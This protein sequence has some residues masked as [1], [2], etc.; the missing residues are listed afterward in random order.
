MKNQDK[1]NVI[2]VG[3]VVNNIGEGINSIGNGVKNFS[4][5]DVILA[6]LKIP[7]VKIDRSK[8]LTKEFL[9]FY[10]VDIIDTAVKH[11]PA[12]AGIGRK[13]INMLADQSITYE[14]SKVS[15][16]SFVAGIP[17][18]FAMIG[19]I[20]ADIIQYFGFILRIMQKLAYLYG[21][22]EFDLNEDEINDETMNLIIVFLGAMFGA[23][24][25][26][27]CIR[28][29]A[30][31]FSEKISKTLAQKALTK[32]TIYP[33]VKKI[34]QALGI[35]MTKQI[36][37]DGA[38]KV[39]PIIG[40][41]ASG[42]LTLFT[43]APCANKLKNNFKDLN[44]SSVEFYKKLKIEKEASNIDSKNSKDISDE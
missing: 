20:P 6:S 8:F 28:E 36:F 40:G 29:V 21:F 3:K 37:A 32:G 25:A 13:R 10:P 27:T 22:P 14:T 12:Y 24:G 42:A 2:D 39:V 1:K 23:E 33:I 41:I 30:K 18:G 16:I 4:L 43:F 19:T 31:A 34:A 17:G 35:R 44:L 5:N 11:N 15:G 7:G 26:S 9:R 38:A